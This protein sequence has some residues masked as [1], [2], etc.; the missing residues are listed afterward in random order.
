MQAVKKPGPRPRPDT[1]KNKVQGYLSDQNKQK[2]EA[3]IAHYEKNFGYAL[4]VSDM[5]TVLIENEAERL[6]IEVSGG[7]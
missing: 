3:I 1:R 2:A 4:S 5:L 7:E 6:G